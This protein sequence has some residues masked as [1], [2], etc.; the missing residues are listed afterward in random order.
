MLNNDPGLIVELLL[1][2]SNT[3]SGRVVKVTQN[4]NKYSSGLMM[5]ILSSERYLPLIHVVNN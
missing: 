2:I 4:T 5:V 1:L 3:S